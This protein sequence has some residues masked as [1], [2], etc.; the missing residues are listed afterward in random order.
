MVST[1]VY[2][3]SEVHSHS[4]LCLFVCLWRGHTDR[5]KDVATSF[6][7]KQYSLAEQP[8]LSLD[9]TA[10]L[11]DH[12]RICNH[13]PK[14]TSCYYDFRNTFS[15][16]CLLKGEKK[17]KCRHLTCRAYCVSV[18][19]RCI[20]IFL[21]FLCLCALAVNRVSAR[22]EL[23]SWC[24]MMPIRSGFQQAVLRASAESTS[25]TIRATTP[26]VW[27]AARSRIIR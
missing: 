26:S 5:R 20:M 4:F 9:L 12:H 21:S 17:K 7:L 19:T 6:E 2:F 14:H 24:M 16:T 18:G 27:W 1:E 8:V 25:T 15:L 10:Y 11:L 23:P 22:R 13:S 3:C